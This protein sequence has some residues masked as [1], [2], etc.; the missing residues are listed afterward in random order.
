[1]N[2]R[3]LLTQ[4]SVFLI[5]LVLTCAG[6]SGAFGQTGCNPQPSAENPLVLAEFHVWH[7]SASHASAFSGAFW[8]PYSRAYDSQ[9]AALISSQIQT[10]KAMG[11]KGF[12]IDWYGPQ[13]TGLANDADRIFQDDAT[14]L[15]FTQAEI[16]GDFCVAVLYDE[17][18]LS[19]SGLPTDDYPDQAELDVGYAE[20]HY[21]SSSAYLELGGAPALFVFPYDSVDPELNWA[22]LRASF[23]NPVTLLR[24]DP[25]P[26]FTADFDGFFAWVQPDSGGFHPLGLEWGRDYLHWFYQTMNGPSY[27]TE[28]AVGG[29]WPGFDDSL[30]PWSVGDG[31]FM[32]RDGTEVWDQTWDIADQYQAEIIM[33]ATWNDYEEGTDVEYG[34]AMIVDMELPTPEILMRSSPITVTWSPAIGEKVLQVYK[35]G[36]LIFDELRSP[37][38]TLYLESGHAYEIKL[39][40]DGSTTLSKTVK[41]RRQDP[42]PALIFWDEFE[43]GDVS[44]WS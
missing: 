42:D 29:V 5:A 37:P 18:A 27:A 41:I 26:A 8:L 23:D 19:E 7:G 4:L 43:S 28:I 38:V 31:R 21:F 33:I 39:W 3:K 2:L 12:V 9:D 40:L 34:I 30:A 16:D 15:V 1:M 24:K 22:T 35:G 36:V 20:D 13:A 10:A 17:G 25:D 32:S 44:E 11:I 6:S 14:A